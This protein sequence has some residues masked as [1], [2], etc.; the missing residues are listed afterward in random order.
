MFSNEIEVAGERK[1]SQIVREFHGYWSDYG[2]GGY[3][4]GTQQDAENFA[5]TIT[6]KERN[7]G[8]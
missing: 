5:K 4:F 8:V 7:Q 3:I 1:F 2:N 6:G